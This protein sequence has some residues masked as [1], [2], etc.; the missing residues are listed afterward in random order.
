MDRPNHESPPPSSLTI[1][2][3]GGYLKVDAKDKSR[4]LKDLSEKKDPKTFKGFVPTSE[5]RK[6]ETEL[7]TQRYFVSSLESGAKTSESK[8]PNTVKSEL[9][10]D[11]VAVTPSNSPRKNSQSPTTT[12]L[13][14]GGST[15]P[16]S[17]DGGSR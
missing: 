8:N 2:V 12:S 13:K 1:F 4:V 6:S 5:P 7:V 15:L 14:D 3:D 16:S 17:K 11:Y 9:G 10:D